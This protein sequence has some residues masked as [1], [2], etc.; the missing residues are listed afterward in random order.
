MPKKKKKK[1][2]VQQMPRTC[3]R[4]RGGILAKNF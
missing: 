3:D 2:P 4:N 1:I